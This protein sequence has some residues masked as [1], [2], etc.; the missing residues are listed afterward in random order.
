[1]SLTNRWTK[2]WKRTASTSNRKEPQQ[3]RSMLKYRGGAG[4]RGGGGC[5]NRF[6]G[7][8]TSPLIH[9]YLWLLSQTLEEWCRIPCPDENGLTADITDFDGSNL[10]AGYR[11]PQES[12]DFS[13]I[14][15]DGGESVEQAR[16]DELKTG[17]AIGW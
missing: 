14:V 3:K 13:D 4:K 16:L 1:M 11:T 6:Y 12:L 7:I 8:P 17:T 10:E 5:L 9:N 2:V 15:R